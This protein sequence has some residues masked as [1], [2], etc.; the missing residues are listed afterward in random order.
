MAALVVAIAGC[1]K[2]L[3]S[4]AG[5]G[6]DGE[7]VF[8]SFSI[9]TIDTKS[10]T[11]NEGGNYGSSDATPDIEVG[12]DYEN[13]ISTVDIVLRSGPTY[14]SATAV[15]PE[16]VNN[17]DADK[18]NYP[19]KWVAKFNSSLLKAGQEYD[20]FVYAN[21]NSKQDLDATS[22]ESIDNMTV[23]E[24]FWMT[25]AYAQSVTFDA[26]ATFSTDENNPTHIG[27][28][29]VERS[30]AR[31]DYKPSGAFE[32]AEG[33]NITLT[34]AALINQ[35]KSFYLLRRV[36]ADGTNTGW[37]VG[38]A[39][40][41]VNYVVDT[42]YAAKNNG[43]Q[44]TDAANFDNHM[45]LGIDNLTFKALPTASGEAD[46][47]EGVGEGAGNFYIWQY[48]KENTIPGAFSNQVNGNSTGVI[49]RGELSGDIV[50]AAAGETI[51]V[52]NNILYGTWANV[53]AAAEVAGAPEAL[54]YACA[55]CTDA[56][57]NVITGNLA[58]A[59]F[60]SYP[61]VEKDGDG[62]NHYYAYYY[63]WNRHNDNLNNQDMGKMEFAVVRNNVYKLYV[64]SIS[65]YGHPG[66]G[67][68][69]PD[70]VDPTDPD[71]QGEYYFSVT[72]KVVP[73]VVRVNHIGW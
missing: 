27:D 34:E 38:G 61:A 39:E 22:S 47:W 56:S 57:G 59:G 9:Q 32:I 20:I 15:T 41:K 30:M 50:T 40:T 1:H 65:K 54:K 10:A 17:P 66:P 60:T 33:V 55:A 24:K 16:A 67:G 53:K 46:N 29:Y 21:C 26:N 8:V 5:N 14:V 73:W 71:E 12:K 52:F 62:A 36:S 58:S 70:P 63:Y 2:E 19:K 51:Y 13:K 4:N 49:F 23:K 44:N 72:V 37:S 45:S 11:D 48:A 7:N 3:Q 43:Y 68:S 31:F 6:I 18:D 28:V 35:S 25:N 69:D 42:D 64:D